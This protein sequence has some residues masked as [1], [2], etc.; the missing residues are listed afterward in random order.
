MWH[1]MPLTKT[2]ERPSLN[3]GEVR[4][5]QLL[6]PILREILAIPSQQ[7]LSLGERENEEMTPRLRHSVQVPHGATARGPAS[8]TES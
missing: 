6:H 5:V 8:A 3:R 1:P 2:M 4:G 7:F